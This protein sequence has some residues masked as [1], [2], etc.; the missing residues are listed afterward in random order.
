MIEAEIAAVMAT[1]IPEN[2]VV[3]V[4]FDSAVAGSTFFSSDVGALVRGVGSFWVPEGV[5]VHINRGA[6]IAARDKLKGTS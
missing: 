3:L 4:P 1:D 5:K 2:D 6:L